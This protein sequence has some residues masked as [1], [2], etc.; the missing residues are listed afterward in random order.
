M[1][2][3]LKLSVKENDCMRGRREVEGFWS[4]LG[5]NSPGGVFDDRT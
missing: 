1:Q 2:V 4:V 5:T 3:V